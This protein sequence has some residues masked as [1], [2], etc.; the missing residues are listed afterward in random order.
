MS[1]VFTANHGASFVQV[2]VLESLGPVVRPASSWAL[3]RPGEFGYAH[4]SPRLTRETFEIGPLL[5][6]AKS[7]LTEPR[8]QACWYLSI[9]DTARPGREGLTSRANRATSGPHWDA[10][11]VGYLNPAVR[12]RMMACARSEI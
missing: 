7:L 5:G 1:L 12:A 2:A 4:R 6:M 11:G 9:V 10:A 8:V 3:P